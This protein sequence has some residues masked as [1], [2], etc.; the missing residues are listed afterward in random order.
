[1]SPASILHSLLETMIHSILTIR[2]KH[3]K[4]SPGTEWFDTNPDDILEI[5]RY[6][7]EDIL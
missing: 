2:G 5:I 4:D 6:I 7:N 1:M 3:I